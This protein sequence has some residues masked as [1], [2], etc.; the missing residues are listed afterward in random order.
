M[1]YGMSVQ[2][3]HT[4]LWGAAAGLAV[5]RYRAKVRYPLGVV[6]GSACMG[7]GAG[8]FH[9][10]RQHAEFARQLDDRLAFLLVLEN[11]NKRIGNHG[12]LFPQLDERKML[13]AIVKRREEAGEILAPGLELIADADSPTDSV[14]PSDAIR[15][16]PGR[17]AFIHLPADVSLNA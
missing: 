8:I 10:F 15:A 9:Y 16:S 11:V 12:S 14:A 5:Y 17:G 3:F 6:G 13:E 4:F 1:L 7:Y 2:Y